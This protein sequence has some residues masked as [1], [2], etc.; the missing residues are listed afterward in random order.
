M[1]IFGSSEESTEVKTVDTN[2]QVNNNIIIREAN[3][4]HSQLDVSSKLLFATYVL[5]SIE[6][7]KFGIYI[8]SGIKR[9]WKKKYIK[10]SSS[11]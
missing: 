6:I 9:Q 11:S 3:D 8:F 5:V 4:I 2:G 10:S 1:G 7:L